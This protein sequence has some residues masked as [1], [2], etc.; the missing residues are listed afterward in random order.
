MPRLIVCLVLFAGSA[1]CQL[2]FKTQTAC[3]MLALE[4]QDVCAAFDGEPQ[5][6]EPSMYSFK[7]TAA[8]NAVSSMPILPEPLG[9]PLAK[10]PLAVTDADGECSPSPCPNVYEAPTLRTRLAQVVTPPNPSPTVPYNF[11]V[12]FNK[13]VDLKL[14]KKQNAYLINL[15]VCNADPIKGIPALPQERILMSSS[16]Y[17]VLT[18]TQAAWFLAQKAGKDPAV[19]IEQWGTLG[20]GLAAGFTGV[21]YIAAGILIVQKIMDYFKAKQPDIT[22]FLQEMLPMEVPLNPA[23]MPG[24]CKT[25]S[26]FAAKGE[27]TI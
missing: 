3:E 2:P 5:V 25:G 4:G 6:S 18:P 8:Y 24:D 22:P 9:N 16:Q 20:L 7:W 17:N 11:A 13:I 1:L 26:L 21:P 19:E 23:G 12:Q 14:G 10:A 15:R 27:S